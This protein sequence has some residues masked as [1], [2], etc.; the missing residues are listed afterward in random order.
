M[1]YSEKLVFD[2]G[3]HIGKDTRNYLRQGYNVVALEASPI[4]VGLVETNFAAELE[5]G[6]L[7]IENV[8]ISDHVGQFTFYMNEYEPEWSSFHPSLGQRGSKVG[9]TFKEIP[10]ECIT[11]RELVDKHG[12]PYFLKIDIES[13]DVKV[14]RTLATL[15]DRPRYI[16]SEE[17][18]LVSMVA[19]YEAGVRKFKFS[20]QEA[21]QS[22]INPLTGEPYGNAC[23][24][25]F[26]EDLAG[27]WMDEYA[28]FNYYTG[29]I[30]EGGKDPNH[31][32]WDIHGKF[33]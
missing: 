5:T 19:L 27:D 12:I 29:F 22:D 31:G 14:I 20:N 30:R 28:A 32:W 23:S 1:A 16:S 33:D 15:P 13:F 3:M 25:P 24:G 8:G 7:V 9:G 26:G 11:L 2:I 17:C 4:M 21:L 6:Q 18:G 10:I